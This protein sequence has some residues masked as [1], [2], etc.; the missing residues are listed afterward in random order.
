VGKDILRYAREGW[1]AIP[2]DDVERLKWWGVFLRKHSEGEP[3]YF[4]V[5]IRIPNGIA[6][7]AQVREIATISA[8]RGRGIADITTRQQIQMRWIRIE[9][10]TLL[11]G[12]GVRE[13]RG[14]HGTGERRGSG[15]Q[16]GGR[17]G[18][19]AQRTSRSC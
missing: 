9:D 18:R 15:I 14:S 13:R 3:G 11:P 6:T 8:E 4:M 19:S 12:S 16:Y 7:A 1:E 10:G 2:K 5:R 17:E